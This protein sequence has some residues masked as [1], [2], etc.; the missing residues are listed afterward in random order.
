[1][2]ETKGHLLFDLTD[3]RNSGRFKISY[4]STFYTR[5]KN[6]H[7][8]EIFTEE[9][10]ESAGPE[11]GF[12]QTIPKAPALTLDRVAQAKLLWTSLCH[13]VTGTEKRE[14]CC[15]GNSETGLKPWQG[16]GGGLWAARLYKLCFLGESGCKDSWLQRLK[17]SFTSTLW[18]S[19]ATWTFWDGSS[20]S[21]AC[22]SRHP[23]QYLKANGIIFIS[24]M[25]SDEITATS[26][27]TKLAAAP[28]QRAGAPQWSSAAKESTDWHFWANSHIGKVLFE[29][30]G[31]SDRE[32]SNHLSAPSIAA[33]ATLLP[34]KKVFQRN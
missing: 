2:K 8:T 10:Q 16:L 7:K 13:C 34:T 4:L 3:H 22:C 11:R 26:L 32:S 28:S 27:Y 5:G 20:G 6:N 33:K 29:Q 30:V 12:P 18:H 24:F 25:G 23:W 9:I 1:M 14:K 21:S 19:Q 15:W 17:P 31:C